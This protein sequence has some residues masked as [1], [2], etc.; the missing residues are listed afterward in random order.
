MT[1]QHTLARG[2]VS[3]GAYLLP[4]IVVLLASVTL[5]YAAS[6]SVTGS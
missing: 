3:T 2:S 5:A 1:G 4:W 6:S